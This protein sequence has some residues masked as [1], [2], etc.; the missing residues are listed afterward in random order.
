MPFRARPLF[1]SP[2]DAINTTLGSLACHIV[3]PDSKAQPDLAVVL[4]HGFGAPGTDLVPLGLEL[5]R[6]HP[7]LASRV[8]FVFPEAPVA[9]PELGYSEARAWW[10]LD[11]ERLAA[12]AQDPAV[13]RQLQDEVPEGLPR[14]RRLLTALVNELSTNSRLPIARIVLGG[15][16]QGAML[17]TDVS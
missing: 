4:C 17:A 10:R 14:S 16:S 7:T 8:R 3:Q 1:L 2:M 11:L 15:F 13:R 12:A 9:M 6:Q 5:P